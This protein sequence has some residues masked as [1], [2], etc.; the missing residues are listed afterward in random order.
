[1]A[2]GAPVVAAARGALPDTVG[3]AGVLLDPDDSDGFAQALVAAVTDAALHAKL[4]DAGRRRAA[5]FTWRATA[6]LTDAVITEVL[7]D[8]QW[9]ASPL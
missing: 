2:A 1:M 5:R 7:S 3:D 4:V 9:R 6:E 8:R